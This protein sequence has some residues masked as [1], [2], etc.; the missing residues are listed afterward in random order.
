MQWL[1][2]TR[3]LVVLILQYTQILSHYVVYMRLIYFMSIKKLPDYNKVL[4]FGDRKPCCSINVWLKLYSFIDQ[5]IKYETLDFF[6][7]FMHVS[8]TEEVDLS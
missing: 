5:M 1:I 4:F 7:H 6:S 2:L 8:R 3:L